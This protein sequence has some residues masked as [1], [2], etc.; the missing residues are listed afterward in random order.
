M[1]ASEASGELRGLITEAGITYPE[2]WSMTL[3]DP[4]EPDFVAD[5]CGEKLVGASIRAGATPSAAELLVGVRN[6]DRSDTAV[7]PILRGRE[8]E[9]VCSPPPTTWQTLLSLLG[10]PAR[11][12]V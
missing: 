7:A 9:S 6:I 11:A 3:R 10:S 12:A 8:G 5:S 1:D 2:V 4:A